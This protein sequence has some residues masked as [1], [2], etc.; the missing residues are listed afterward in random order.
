MGGAHS[1]LSRPGE[2]VHPAVRTRRLREV[3]TLTVA[4]I[5]TVALAMAIYL[6]LSFEPN[7]AAQNP[8]RL[9][10]EPALMWAVCCCSVIVALLLF[11]DMPWLHSLFAPL[12]SGLQPRAL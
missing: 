2:R 6:K 4:G 3:A 9:Y 5:V 11:V 1:Y 8:E 12:S 7:S 10:R